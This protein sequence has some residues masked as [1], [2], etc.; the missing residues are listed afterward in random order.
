MNISKNNAAGLRFNLQEQYQENWEED[1][2]NV[3]GH[4]QAGFPPHGG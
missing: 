4:N 2:S 3:S 1:Q